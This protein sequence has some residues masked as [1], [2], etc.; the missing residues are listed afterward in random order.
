MKTAIITGVT[1]QDGSYLAK[2]LLHDGYKVFGFVREDKFDISCSK[3]KNL[4]CLSEKLELISISISNPDHVKKEVSSIKPDELYHLAAESYVSY[5]MRNEA[6]IMDMNFTSTLNIVSS[7][8]DFSPKCRMFF[9]GSSEMFGDPD[10]CPQNE[11]SKF[12][13]KSIYGISKVASYY[14]LKNYRKKDSMYISTGIMYNHE[15]PRRDNQFVTK[16]IISSAV[17]IKHGDLSVLELGNLDALR[18]WGYAPDYTS[19]MR[20]ILRQDYPDDYV[21]ATGKLHSVK[22][23]VKITFEYLDLDYKKYIKFNPKL[24]RPAEK[25]PLCGDYTKLSNLGWTHTKDLTKVIQEM[26]DA[27]INK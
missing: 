15:S 16:K 12:N 10:E 2:Q 9:A 19:A 4:E 6:N 22:D 17:K 13:P 24:F 5:D 1:G 25:N 18:D 3:L 27:E 11:F 14:L 20:L 23:F 21:L 7:L 26:V 8:R